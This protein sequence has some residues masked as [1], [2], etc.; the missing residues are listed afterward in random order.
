VFAVYFR[1][2]RTDFILSGA[3]KESR[4]LATETDRIKKSR[5]KAEKGEQK[6]TVIGEITV[7][8]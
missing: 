5:K 4:K 3:A 1:L 7:Q 2:G 6:R 8:I